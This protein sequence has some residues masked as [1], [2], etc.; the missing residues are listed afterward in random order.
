MEILRNVID[1][2]KILYGSFEY[3]QELS[4]SRKKTKKWNFGEE[5]P[6]VISVILPDG[7]IDTEID[8]SLGKQLVD[9]KS[10]C[11][12]GLELKA[13]NVLVTPPGA[14]QQEWHQDYGDG[15]YV[16]GLIPLNY[17]GNTEILNCKNSRVNPG[18]I[19]MLS[20]ETWHRGVENK[21]KRT[22]VAIYLVF[23]K[24]NVHFSGEIK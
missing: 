11:P 19:L 10:F 8:L 14:K 2:N 4:K 7:R 3:T 1:V 17:V 23:A 20:G 18:D 6:S 5:F 24:D 16:M 12:E 22:N 9:Y 13:V 15:D 21:T